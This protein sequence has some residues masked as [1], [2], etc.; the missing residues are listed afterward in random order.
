MLSL[1][2]NPEETDYIRPIRHDGKP[3]FFRW[4]YPWFYQ[5]Y[6]YDEL[7]KRLDQS[8]I[9]FKIDPRWDALYADVLGAL[10]LKQVDG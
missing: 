10:Q 2:D 1:A 7:T 9:Y 6:D 8:F 4:E 3:S 5:E